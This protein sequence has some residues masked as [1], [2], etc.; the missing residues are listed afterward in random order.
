MRRRLPFLAVC[1]VAG[2][3]HAPPA[4]AVPPPARDDGPTP[5]AVGE[6][7]DEAT[8]KTVPD[9][10]APSAVGLAG[11]GVRLPVEIAALLAKDVPIDKIEFEIGPD[12]AVEEIAVYHQDAASVPEAVRATAGKAFPGARTV[13]FELEWLAT[14]ALVHEVEVKTADGRK[15]EVSSAPDGA[16]RYTECE[17]G[18]RELP[19]PVRKAVRGLGKVV[20]AEHKKT[21]DGA[22]TYE[23]ELDGR[24]GT[25]GIVVVDPAGNVVQRRRRFTAEVSAPAPI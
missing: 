21:A 20:E 12:G 10:A 4:P 23:I 17:I 14:G 6:G 22:E 15:C 16:A 13:A 11:A 2:C 25:V 24:D 5:P 9:R 1:L 3:L 18:A 7:F 8:A 19:A